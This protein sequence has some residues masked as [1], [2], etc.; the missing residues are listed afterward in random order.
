MNSNFEHPNFLTVPRVSAAEDGDGDN[1]EASGG[2]GG[3][4]SDGRRWQP[5][6]GV[7]AVPV[8]QPSDPGASES[9]P[10]CH[11]VV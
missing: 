8:P 9:G 5:R 10:Q 7:V 4:A 1:A 11:L 3:R 2:N 6:V